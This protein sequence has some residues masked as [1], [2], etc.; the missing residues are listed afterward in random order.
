MFYLSKGLWVKISS[1]PSHKAPVFM[2]SYLPKENW[3]KDLFKK[4]NYIC[5][6]KKLLF[7]GQNNYLLGLGFESETH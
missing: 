1:I 3:L 7:T 4:A 5:V 6:N 2:F